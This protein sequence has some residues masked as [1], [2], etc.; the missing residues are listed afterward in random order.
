MVS[1]VQVVSRASAA[2]AIDVVVERHCRVLRRVHYIGLRSGQVAGVA[3]AAVDAGIGLVHVVAIVG[4]SLAA[5]DAVASKEHLIR[6]SNAINAPVTVH[7]DG[8][9]IVTATEHLSRVGHISGVE[10]AQ[11]KARQAFAANEHSCHI[12]DLPGVKVTHV[13][14]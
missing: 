8:R 5:H 4:R 14:A 10:T 13:D 2:A 12:G 6:Q 1:L 7:K 9:Q 3:G 11:V